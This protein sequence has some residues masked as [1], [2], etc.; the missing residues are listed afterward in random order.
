M[1]KKNYVIKNYKGN[2]VESLSK[3]QKKFKNQRIVEAVED[4]GKLK[5]KAVEEAMSDADQELVDGIESFFEEEVASGALY[6]SDFESNK[7]LHSLE[8]DP[9]ENEKTVN[10]CKHYLK[11]ECGI[12]VFRS[13]EAYDDFICDTL[14]GL[15]K[16]YLHR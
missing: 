2:L 11:D 1:K 7:E 14:Q 6:D 4:E 5:I 9:F 16:D 10:A 13:E 12:D 3:F 8:R 15:A